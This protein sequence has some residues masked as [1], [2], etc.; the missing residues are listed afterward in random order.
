MIERFTGD[1]GQRLRIEAFASQKLVVGNR[2][3]AEE[4]ARCAEIMVVP[5]GDTLIEHRVNGERVL[6]YRKPVVGGGI[7][8]GFKADAKRDGQALTA[9]HISLQSESHPVQFRRLELLNLRGCKN[10]QAAN[11]RAYLAQHDETL[12]LWE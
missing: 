11:Y 10:R 9:G 6:H 4:L 8:S 3:L 2:T 5:A 1:K 7:V 12:C